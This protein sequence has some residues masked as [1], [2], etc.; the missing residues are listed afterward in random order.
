MKSRMPPSES[1]PADCEF[2]TPG[3]D[4]SFASGAWPAIS[5]WGPE[6]PLVQSQPGCLQEETRK[7]GEPHSKH[8]IQN[9][10][11]ERH[12]RFA[13]GDVILAFTPIHTEEKR[14]TR[15]WSA[16][17]AEIVHWM[18]AVVTCKTVC[19]VAC[20]SGAVTGVIVPVFYTLA[21]VQTQVL[22]IT[23]DVQVFVTNQPSLAI[24]TNTVHELCLFCF[25]QVRSIVFDTTQEVNV[26]KTIAAHTVFA[27]Q[28]ALVRLSRIHKWTTHVLIAGSPVFRFRLDKLAREASKLIITITALARIF[29]AGTTIDAKQVIVEVR[30]LG[31]VRR[32]PKLA[33][34]P[35]IGRIACGSLAAVAVVH[36]IS[37]D[38]SF[39]AL[40]PMKAIVGSTGFALNFTGF[41]VVSFRTRTVLMIGSVGSKVW[42]GVLLL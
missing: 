26:L 8:R 37:I 24:G 14:L 42:V 38:L 23:T 27:F 3:L 31:T 39:N 19:F 17:C 18:L 21:T 7:W 1:P 5:Q 10:I 35:R 34:S 6:K 25:S 32:R 2:E 11:L 36:N 13:D 12:L 15:T 28:I 22:S 29:P 40:A 41:A 9:I 16:G 4:G 20:R 30:T 33:E